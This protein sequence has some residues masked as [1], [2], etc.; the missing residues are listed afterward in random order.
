MVLRKFIVSLLIEFG[1]VSLFFIGAL[2][3]DFFVG[4][5]LLMGAT[6]LSVIVSLVRDGRVPL[7]SL[8]ASFFV[9]ASGALTL[10]FNDPF[11]V[12]V[13]YTLYNLCFG[14]AMLIGYWYDKPALK[15]L[16]E[17]MFDLTD[18]GWHV[19]SLRWGLFF[20]LTAV[21][22]ELTWRI[23]SY[24]EW[25]WYRFVMVIVLGVFGFSQFFLA[26]R[27]R[28]HTASAWGLRK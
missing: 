2:V 20:L 18:R 4:V 22:S 23:A 14:I 26:R 13:E 11:W 5:A 25:V 8:I 3:F 9:L 24:D 10:Y 28:A 7:F 17:T 1:P 12:V 6:V 19:L 27:E 16:F 15:P 21:G